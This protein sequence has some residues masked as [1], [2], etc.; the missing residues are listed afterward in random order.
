M[1]KPEVTVRFYAALRARA[2][3]DEILCRAANVKDVI[4]HLKSSFGTDF[5]RVLNSCHIFLNEENIVFMRGLSTRL[6]EGDTLHILPPTG[7][8]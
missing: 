1:D 2:G 4:R 3:S 7:G 6:K 8:G 5:N